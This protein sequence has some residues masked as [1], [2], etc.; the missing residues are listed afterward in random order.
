MSLFE[1][2]LAL[3]IFAGAAAAIG[4]LLTNG[5]RG[6]VHARNQTEAVLRC[7]SKLAEVVAGAQAFQASANVPYTDNPDWTWSL[8]IN[9]TQQPNLML[10]EV[11]TTYMG[12][13]ETADVSFTLHRM[14]RNPQLLFNAVAESTQAALNLATTNS[15]TSSSSTSGSAGG[16]SSGGGSR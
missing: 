8:T 4:Q 16:A 1:V 13:N 3:A 14:M 9:N 7:E 6:A 2:L 11:T 12:A 5:V 10:V 15:T